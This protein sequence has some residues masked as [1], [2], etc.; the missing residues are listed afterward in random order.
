MHEKSEKA[1]IDKTLQKT[2]DVEGARPY[3]RDLSTWFYR[4]TRDQHVAGELAPILNA[5]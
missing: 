5:E 2:D 1:F 4:S 3:T